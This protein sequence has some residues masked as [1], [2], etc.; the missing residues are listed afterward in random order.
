VQ[1]LTGCLK[2]LHVV[3]GLPVGT[4]DDVLWLSFRLASP[5][6]VYCNYVQEYP[7][8]NVVCTNCI[9]PVQYA[10]TSESPPVESWNLE[11][12]NRVPT[13]CMYGVRTSSRGFEKPVLYVNCLTWRTDIGH[14]PNA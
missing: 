7:L 11:P 12:H 10:R 6:T 8:S 14:P 4:I 2:L 5:M 9:G 3:S 13:A 1:Q